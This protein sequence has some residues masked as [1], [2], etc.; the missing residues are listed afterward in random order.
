MALSLTKDRT[1]VVR[2]R[3]IRADR[4]HGINDELEIRPK[5]N[6]AETSIL[7]TST[8]F[9]ASVNL[10]LFL[11][12]RHEVHVVAGCNVVAR[13][14]ELLCLTNPATETVASFEFYSF[15]N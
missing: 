9:V 7:L 5:K 3:G 4:D 2:N 11:L 6:L 13:S 1:S 8:F 14:S 12:G 15:N 10:K